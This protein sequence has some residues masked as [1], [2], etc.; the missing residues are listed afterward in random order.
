MFGSSIIGVQLAAIVLGNGPQIFDWPAVFCSEISLGDEENVLHS[1][2]NHHR[3]HH[4]AR[5]VKF[6]GCFFLI[7]SNLSEP[8][9]MTLELVQITEGR[10]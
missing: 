9:N 2:R 5:S 10:R 8:E 4:Q 6:A 7:M 1:F 3:Y